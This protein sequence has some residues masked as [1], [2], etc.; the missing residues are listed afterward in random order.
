MNGMTNAQAALMA[1]AATDTAGDLDN[2]LYVASEYLSWLAAQDNAPRA[3]PQV[4]QCASLSSGGTRCDGWAP[5]GE[6]HSGKHFNSKH[7][8]IWG[9]DEPADSAPKVIDKPAT[10]TAPARHFLPSPDAG[11]TTCGLDLFTGNR[12]AGLKVSTAVKDVTCDR[13]KVELGL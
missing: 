10:V 12:W 1:A 8:T 13:C 6:R 2:V 5:L 9:D 3:E 11:V 7:G 4:A